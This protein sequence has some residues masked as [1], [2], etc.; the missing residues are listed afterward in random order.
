MLTPGGCSNAYSADSCISTSVMLLQTET[1]CLQDSGYC[2]LTS[3]QLC[4]P[5]W[6]A[7][8]G[9]KALALQILP[10]KSNSCL[11][12][13]M[14]FAYDR[15]YRFLMVLEL[16]LFYVFTRGEVTTFAFII[17]S[18]CWGLGSSVLVPN[19]WCFHW[20]NCLCRRVGSHALTKMHTNLF[21]NPCI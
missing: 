20:E 2:P 19:G 4:R 3:S 13:T 5:V 8:M 6:L 18:W 21:L 1:W 7:T 12:S 16:P 11:E 10:W 14:G 15:I 9:G 17:L